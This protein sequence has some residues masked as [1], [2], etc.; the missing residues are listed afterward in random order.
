MKQ[1]KIM[2]ICFLNL[3]LWLPFAINNY[4][5][6][7]Y[8]KNPTLINF[9]KILILIIYFL[10]G[11]MNLKILFSYDFTNKFKTSYLYNSTIESLINFFNLVVIYIFNNN[12]LKMIKYSLAI[13]FLLI[14]YLLS[15]RMIQICNYYPKY[16][17]LY[18]PNILLIFFSFLFKI[19][20]YNQ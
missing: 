3:F 1:A 17:I 16:L 20:L 14:I 9:I 19:Y 18:Y 15:N 5:I 13:N 7:D 12:F 8:F 11:V 2:L 4:T 6:Y 10:D